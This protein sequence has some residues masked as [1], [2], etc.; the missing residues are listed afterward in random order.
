MSV[1]FVHD[2]S[3][4]RDVIAPSGFAFLFAISCNMATLSSNFELSRICRTERSLR[5]PFRAIAADTKRPVYR[6]LKI[7]QRSEHRFITTCAASC[8]LCG[9][10]GIG[11][12]HKLAIWEPR[13]FHCSKRTRRSVLDRPIEIPSYLR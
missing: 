1:S 7:G 9:A 8:I 4:I 6:I 11:G 13:D 12:L 2:C 3:T 5:E 10:S